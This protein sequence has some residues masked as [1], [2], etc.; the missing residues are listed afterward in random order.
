V[1]D[2]DDGSAVMP[3][4]APARAA[5]RWTFGRGM[6]SEWML[7]P[8][9]I[10]L[11]HGTVG[12]PPRRVL[13]AQQSVRDEI[14][15]HPAR[16]LIRELADLKGAEMRTKP[17]MRVAAE[18]V[19]AFV[20]ARADDL[21][22]V[23]NTTAG[24]NAVLRSFA[25][26]PGD[27]ILLTDV[28]YGSIVHI[29]EYVASR[30]GAVVRTV[31]LPG[32]PFEPAAITGALARAFT[33]RTRV[34]VVDHITSGTALILP[35]Q[36][37]AAL[38]R[39]AGIA[40]LVDGAHVPGAIP[41]DIPSLGVDWYIGNLHKWAMAPL[42]SGIL[43]AAPSRHPGLHPPVISWGYQK[44]LAAEFDLPATRD[45][46]PWLASPAGI[47]FMH[48]LGLDAMREYNHAFVMTAARRLCDRWNIAVPA[49]ESMIGCMVSLQ[50]PQSFGTSPADSA[51]LKDA[52]LYEHRVE[53]LLHSFKDRL[54]MRLCGQVYNDASDIDHLI[55][56]TEALV[57]K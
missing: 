5:Q 57:G 26:E 38:A 4:A 21:M 49:P 30:T 56:A 24:V 8:E 2:L 27:E 51:R 47:Q 42:S 55:Q 12:A 13:A 20:G 48:E 16:F 17:R 15:R 34:L 44:G 37:I 41:L 11:N 31:Q 18:A 22:F 6:L 1:S 29:A 39:A 25:F 7:E 43:W 52:L 33:S 50:L 45:P 3:G 28:G 19:A 53:L 14:A 23:D 46:S 36:E 10:Y 40:V 35:V 32:P 54:W 9:A